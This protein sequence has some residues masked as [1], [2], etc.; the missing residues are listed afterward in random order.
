MVE[1]QTAFMAAI[2]DDCLPAPDWL[3]VMGLHLQE[4]PGVI[5][6]GR[7]EAA[8]NGVPQTVVIS[9]TPFFMSSL[10]IRNLSPLA[11]GNMGVSFKLAQQIGTF[12]EN[13][14]TAEDTDWAYRA[15]RAGIP[16]LYAPDVVVH[17]HHW[18]D[19]AQTLS[20]YQAYAMGLGCFYGKYL[21]RGDWS[22]VPRTLLALYRGAK[23]L[24]KGWKNQDE[25]L[26]LEG[27]ARL[28]RLIPGMIDGLRGFK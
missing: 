12:D 21:R 27:K 20:N 10:S 7:V 17:H 2:D 13:L 23:S 16:V 18:R 3:E 8:G 14:Y 11:T 6:T 4:N 1:V 25:N 28:T 9:T 24:A 22:M 26:I 19:S 5:V 15:M